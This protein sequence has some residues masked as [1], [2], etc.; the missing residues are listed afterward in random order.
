[1]E[2]FVAIFTASVWPVTS[3]FLAIFFHKPIES[4]LRIIEERIKSG[5]AFTIPHILSMATDTKATAALP[6]P[7]HGPRAAFPTV[8]PTDIEDAELLAVVVRGVCL[9][10][11]LNE[12]IAESMH[13]DLSRLLIGAGLIPLRRLNENATAAFMQRPLVPFD[14]PR[15]N[16]SWV[17]LQ[18]I[19]ILNRLVDSIDNPSAPDGYIRARVIQALELKDRLKKSGSEL[20]AAITGTAPSA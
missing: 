18:E 10:I 6:S 20:L 4:V 15:I 17:Y 2:H 14:D 9:E 1:M 16:L 12:E 8:P 19:R 11:Y 13:G 7:R 3:V 5:D